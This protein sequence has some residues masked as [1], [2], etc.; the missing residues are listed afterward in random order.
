MKTDTIIGLSCHPSILIA[1]SCL[2][3]NQMQ[4]VL[5]FLFMYVLVIVVSLF[6][7][8]DDFCLLSPHHHHYRY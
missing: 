2:V 1:P 7:F 5:I 6:S 4:L 3:F 8:Y